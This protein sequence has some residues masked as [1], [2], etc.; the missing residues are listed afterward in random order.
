MT[1]KI[2]AIFN[3]DVDIAADN[4]G[5]LTADYIVGSVRTRVFVNDERL[6]AWV[7]DLL[8]F[9]RAGRHSDP[10]ISFYIFAVDGE[11]AL[12]P[13][14][15]HEGRVLY[16]CSMFT[17]WERGSQRWLEVPDKGVVW[18]DLAVNKAVAFV[19]VAGLDSAWVV[20]H[21]ILYPLWIQM[22]K[23][24]GLYHLHAACVSLN[25]KGLLLPGHAG[26]GKTTL[27]INLVRNGFSFFG[28]DTVFLRPENGA[29]IVD[30]FP[31]EVK[32]RKGSLDLFPELDFLRAHDPGSLKPKLQFKMQDVFKDCVQVPAVV[33][34]VIVFPKITRER[35]TTIRPKSKAEALGTLLKYCLFMAD[36]SSNNKHFNILGDLVD[37]VPCFDADIGTDNLG[38]AL[39]IRELVEGIS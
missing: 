26:C 11:T 1:A 32:L 6:H 3:T 27:A 25:G 9:F 30:C 21:Y 5:F 34:D 19:D 29:I 36:P 18:C 15:K 8:A 24:E 4:Q 37:R 22:L 39:M 35:A 33:P 31:E 20:G 10:I 17:C 7:D 28:D 12:T 13:R 2:A 38:S 16:Q 14:D 23:N